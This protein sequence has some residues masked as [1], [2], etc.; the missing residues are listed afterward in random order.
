MACVLAIDQSTSATKA[1]LFDLAGDV[2]DS[3]SRKHEQF[4]PQPGWVE[5]DAEEIWRNMLAVTGEV[6][7]RQSE[8]IADLA[9]ISIANQR[10]TIVVFE[11]RTGRPLCPAIVWQCRRGDSLC[12]MQIQLQREAT[13]RERTGLR[14]DG[15][16]SASKLQWLMREREDLAA[17]VAR[18]E[19][20][21]GTIDSYLIYRL[22]DGAV[23]ATDPTNASRTLLYDIGALR[24]DEELCSWWQVP[25]RA[26]AEVRPSSAHFGDTTLLGNWR[27][28]CR[29]V[30]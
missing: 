29:F 4:Y 2:L 22:T 5:H 16:F 3:A 27:K 8:R 9:C 28:R 24:W 13:V 14:I 11:R 7:A 15:Y 26:L 12:A 10:E 6:L 18:G 25:C 20:L 1:A 17:L 30:A 23:F 19:A 21:I